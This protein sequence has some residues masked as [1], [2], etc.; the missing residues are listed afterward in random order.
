MAQLSDTIT[1]DVSSIQT[2]NEI[3]QEVLHHLE[4][5]LVRYSL[6][7]DR[8]DVLKVASSDSLDFKEMGQGANPQEDPFNAWVFNLSAN[9]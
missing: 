4:L 3:R 1:F 9:G 7:L 6:Y 2:E 8:H 5:G